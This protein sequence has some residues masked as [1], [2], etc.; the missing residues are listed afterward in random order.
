MVRIAAESEPASG[1]VIAIAAQLPAEARELLLG[2]DRRDRG[3][4]QALAR[5]RQREA[6]VAPAQLD[7]WPSTVDMLVP[8]RPPVGL[9][10]LLARCPQVTEVVLLLVS[11]FWLAPAAPPAPVPVPEAFRPSMTAENRSS[12]AGVV[13]LAEVVLARDRAEHLIG[14]G[15]G[16]LHQRDELPWESR[17]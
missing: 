3:V 5:D 7:A 16:L 14:D 1:S 17:D 10:G 8:L 13:M 9:R 4:A 2:G 6:D 15:A 11:V 12:S